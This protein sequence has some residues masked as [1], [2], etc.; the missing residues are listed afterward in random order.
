[1]SGKTAKANRK[2]D[3]ALPASDPS[4]SQGVRRV[5]SNDMSTEWT[6]AW[7]A[8]QVHHK[9]WEEKERLLISRLGDSISSQFKSRVTDGRLATIVIE[10]AARVMAQLPTGTV[11][12][13]TKANKGLSTL[14]G[15]FLTK[16]IQHKDNAQ[17]DHLTKMR[18]VDLYSQVYG[19]VPVLYD[20]SVTEKYLGPASWIIPIRRWF[21]Q[22]GKLSIDDSDYNFVET[23]VS[24]RQLEGMKGTG[25]WITAAL[26]EVIKRA[27]KEGGAS[28]ADQPSNSQTVVE[29]ERDPNVPGG[30]GEAAGIRM[31]TRYGQ[32]NAGRWIT[33]FPDFD[34]LI[35]R[36]CANK[37]GNIPIEL[38]HHIPL[39][40]SIYGLGAF[41]RGKTI[42]FAMDSLVAMYMAGVQMSI[43]PPRIIQK[44]EV[45]LSSMEYEPGKTW[46]EKTK[47]AI[48]NYQVSP[49]GMQTF[50]SVYGWLTGSLLNQN[51]TTD[52]S[53]TVQNTNDPTS[54]KTP[55]ALKLQQARES[56]A[57]NWDRFQ[58]EKFL[59]RLYERMLN[60]AP[61]TPKPFTFHIFDAEITQLKE[62]GIKDE[63]EVYDSGKEAKIT[64]TSG[65]FKNAQYMFIID[66]SSTTAQ[67]QEAEHIAL[68]EI[69]TTLAENPQLQYYLGQAGKML[70]LDLL[71]E[72][73]VQS[74]GLSYGDELVVDLPKPKA[75]KPVQLS[76]AQKAELAKR[77]PAEQK[78]IM[79]KLQQAQGGA[80]AA[81]QTGI[82]APPNPMFYPSKR[83][84]ESIDYADLP[85]WAQVQL[86]PLGGVQIPPKVMEMAQADADNP[87]PP[88]DP[89]AP[90][91]GDGPQPADDPDHQFLLKWF[92]QLSIPAQ[93]KIASAVVGDE[94][95]QGITPAEAKI[96]Q[97]LSSKG[98]SDSPAAGQDQL[99][100]IDPSSPYGAA[101]DP[102]AHLQGVQDPATRALYDH[103]VKTAQPGVPLEATDPAT[104]KPPVP[105]A[106]AP[107]AG[108]TQ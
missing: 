51:G 57:D 102:H 72:R 80:G 39:L 17:F 23:W 20:I 94:A 58:M 101:V 59:Q 28:P 73:W 14:M 88:V 3:I 90:K 55:Q 12:A 81:G 99:P 69:I 6:E 42:Q 47:D 27:S 83:M 18:M 70:K 21:P 22:P 63:V 86:L 60:I 29:R 77:P 1:M 34:D 87:K 10:R 40:D 48:R 36:D 15:L 92:D 98:L 91:P 11:R 76:A 24:A 32:G 61:Q 103:I 56:A 26:D 96:V 85:L 82:G 30:K 16:Y 44:D 53:Q 89:N 7:T 13:L 79:A 67:D 74:G 41:E 108:V 62:A 104:G 105:A 19:V 31:V 106:G 71:I 68:T 107:T 93:R 100:E 50:Q 65:S 49:D 38:K 97:D 9:S 46:I 37:D 75:A 4:A 43:F 33:F 8:Q 95:M 5:L 52:T 35:G 84:I 64:L 66:T 78:A 2:S 45:V 25:T 54:G